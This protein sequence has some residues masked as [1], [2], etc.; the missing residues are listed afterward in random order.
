[1]DED[2]LNGVDDLFV[3]VDQR[4]YHSKP[5]EI[6]SVGP[7]TSL[8]I[9]GTSIIRCS[10]QKV[11]LEEYEECDSSRQFVPRC[12]VVPDDR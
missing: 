12:K 7:A 11:A 5:L 6:G 9:S 10:A 4:D 8:L 3:G 1:M 2:D